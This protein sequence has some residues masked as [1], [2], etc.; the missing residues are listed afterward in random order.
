MKTSKCL[1]L[2]TLFL[3]AANAPHAKI[4]DREHFVVRNSS[5]GV[6]TV[7][8]EF[9]Y[10]PRTALSLVAAS[11]GRWSQTIAGTLVGRNA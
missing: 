10:G 2:L 4:P 1:C 6:V 8:A 7:N 5:R 3:L 9:W 11:D